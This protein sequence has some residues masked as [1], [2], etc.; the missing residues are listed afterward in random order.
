[1]VDFGS[2]Q[3]RG[4]FETAGIALLFRKSVN[5]YAIISKMRERRPGPKDAFF[6]QTLN[7]MDNRIAHYVP[8]F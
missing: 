4:I 2:G 3:G 8:F 1:M 7:K 6:G 5:G